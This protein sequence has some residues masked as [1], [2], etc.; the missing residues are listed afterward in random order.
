MSFVNS[1]YNTT[2]YTFVKWENFYKETPKFVDKLRTFGEVGLIL[3]YGKQKIKKCWTTKAR[4]I[5][6][7]DIQ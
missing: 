1:K 3:D 4:Y 2:Y 6:L 5:I 7:W